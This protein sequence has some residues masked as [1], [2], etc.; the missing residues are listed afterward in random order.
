MHQKTKVAK[1]R[2]TS[3]VLTDLLPE[4]RLAVVSKPSDLKS[5]SWAADYIGVTSET[6]RTWAK[7]GR[8][9]YVRLPSGQYRFRV[10]DLD[11]MVAVTPPTVQAAS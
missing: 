5:S 9:P 4:A 1:T 3:S 7:D 2:R 8:I 10:E 6:L 11:A